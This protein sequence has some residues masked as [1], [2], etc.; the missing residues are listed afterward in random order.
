M[1]VKNFEQLLMRRFPDYDDH[2]IEDII[3]QDEVTQK[4]PDCCFRKR[5]QYTRFYVSG[6]CQIEPRM[7][8]Q[9]W[10]PSSLTA[11]HRRR[12]GAWCAVGVV[13][14]F[15]ESWS[16]VE[17]SRSAQKEI[18]HLRLLLVCLHTHGLMFAFL[19]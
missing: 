1:A 9:G 11:I 2:A 15:V 3:V 8:L 18:A 19:S 14:A 12:L 4:I 10:A 6:K 7:T 13:P 16:W 5:A 17:Q